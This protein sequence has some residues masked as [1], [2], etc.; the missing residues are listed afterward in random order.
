MNAQ[1]T[2]HPIVYISIIVASSSALAYGK[3]VLVEE[4]TEQACPL[5]FESEFLRCIGI[6][7]VP[8]GFEH[9]PDPI[10]STSVL[11]TSETSLGI[12]PVRAMWDHGAN[13]L[14]MWMRMQTHASTLTTTSNVLVDV[15]APR[16]YILN[17]VNIL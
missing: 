6:N 12:L 7:Y 14:V 11:N 3:S 1:V 10:R 13:F 5:C 2:S 9:L 15:R 17:S 8:S 16:L 4:I